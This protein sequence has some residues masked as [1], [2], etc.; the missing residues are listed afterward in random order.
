MSKSQ[1][2]TNYIPIP[3]KAARKIAEKYQKE[4][5]IINAY[6]TKFRL[7]QTTTYGVTTQLGQAAAKG[8]ELAAQALGFDIDEEQTKHDK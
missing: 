5:V 2:T 6:D 4:I 8:G 1:L 3:V 7:L